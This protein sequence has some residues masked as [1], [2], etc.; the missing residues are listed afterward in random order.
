MQF[1]EQTAGTSM[2]SPLSPVLANIFMEEFMSSFLL[3]AD[4]PRLWLHYV[5]DTFIVRPH[6][7]DSTSTP[8]PQQQHASISFTMQ[9]EQGGTIPFPDFKISRNLDGT[10]GHSFYR[11]LTPTDRY[12]HQRSF[13]HPS[14]KSSVNWTLVQSL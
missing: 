6:G 8:V 13:H 3:T 14:F 4:Q 1:Y 12:L 5:D 11:K 2:G 9:Q 7:P 10:L